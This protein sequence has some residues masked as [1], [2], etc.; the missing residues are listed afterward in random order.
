MTDNNEFNQKYKKINSYLSNSQSS[1]FDSMD[2]LNNQKTYAGI[3]RERCSLNLFSCRHD[4]I[5]RL[6]VELS[7][8]NCKNRS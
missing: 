5:V 4:K 3:K 7:H 6:V 8:R 2:F 1:F